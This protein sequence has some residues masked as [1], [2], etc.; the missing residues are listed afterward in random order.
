MAKQLATGHKK[1]AFVA[2][3][4]ALDATVLQPF[5]I[6]G[7]LEALLCH[8]DK[9]VEA[10][11]AIADGKG[12]ERHRNNVQLGRF[13]RSRS[14]VRKSPG[15]NMLSRGAG[16]DNLLQLH[17]S[18]KPVALVAVAILDSTCRTEQVLDPITTPTRG[19]GIAWGKG[20]EMG[21]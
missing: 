2:E 17:P 3:P 5:E 1:Q 15:A 9:T 21:V 4:M 14:N 6:G 20:A 12:K 10:R 8:P 16:K 11:E 13:G 19:F 7:R 18:V